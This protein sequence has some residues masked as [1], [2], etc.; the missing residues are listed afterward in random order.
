MEKW[1]YYSHL[2]HLGNRD[3]QIM[4]NQDSVWKTIRPFGHIKDYRIGTVT[5][6]RN[7]Q[8]IIEFLNG[9]PNLRFK[10]HVAQKREFQITPKGTLLLSDFVSDALPIAGDTIYYR[11]I[12]TKEGGRGFT[13]AAEW[14]TTSEFDSISWAADA[15][16]NFKIVP[17]LNKVFIVDHSR[18]P[19]EATQ[20]E[21]EGF[22]FP[23][24]IAEG[25]LIDLIRNYPRKQ[26][27]DHNDPLSFFRRKLDPKKRGV[28]VLCPTMWLRDMVNRVEIVTDRRP[29]F[30]I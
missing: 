24:L 22:T 11:F 10:A 7:D 21:I 17:N 28:Y 19:R 13:E 30:A 2:P 9:D 27:S 29:V 8:P 26:V 16:A 14:F 23:D 20:A 4:N 15:R 1:L 3:I 25:R 6:K 18:D 5:G 12:S